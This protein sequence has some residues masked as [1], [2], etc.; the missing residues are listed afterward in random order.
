M[1]LFNTYRGLWRYRFID[2]RW[3][4]SATSRFTIIIKIHFSDAFSRKYTNN[5]EF[6]AMH[7][8]YQLSRASRYQF[9][10]LLALE[11]RSDPFL[12]HGQLRPHSPPIQQPTSPPNRIFLLW[13]A[14]P[15]FNSYTPP[16]QRSTDI[17]SVWELYLFIFFFFVEPSRQPGAKLLSLILLRKSFSYREST[18][19]WSPVTDSTH[20]AL[21]SKRFSR[22]DVLLIQ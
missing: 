2:C 8:T 6:P 18:L 21:S 11:S 16:L 9:R 7:A 15:L 5:L 10:L 14:S 12:R 20:S 3:W 19:I 17:S 1:I 22:V 13:P 4:P